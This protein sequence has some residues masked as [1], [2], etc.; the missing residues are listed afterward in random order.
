VE[1]YD[2]NYI[3]L[4][5]EWN[6][7]RK[8]KLYL[9]HWFKLHP[10][11]KQQHIKEVDEYELKV[12]K[13]TMYNEYKKRLLDMIRDYRE[14]YLNGMTNLSIHNNSLNDSIEPWQVKLNTALACFVFGAMLYMLD[15]T[16]REKS[17]KAREKGWREGYKK[18]FDKHL[19]GKNLS[20]VFYKTL[21][22]YGVKSGEKHELSSASNTE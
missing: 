13:T 16:S 11:L 7:I 22:K 9:K 1:D 2:K 12:Y 20:E 21:N 3:D 18:R 8:D 17:E 15:N 10:E 14:D 4:L 6:E 5:A 19:T